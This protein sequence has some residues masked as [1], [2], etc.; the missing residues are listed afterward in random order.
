MNNPLMNQNQNQ[1]QNTGYCGANHS[2]HC[3]VTQ[4][5]NHCQNDPYCSLEAIQVGTHE[6]NPTVK[7]C[8]DCMSFEAK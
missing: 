3:T 5:K 6:S 1:N 8:T 4:C 7:P 2:I